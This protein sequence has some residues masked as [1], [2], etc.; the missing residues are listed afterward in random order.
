M[1]RQSA[2]AHLS[3]AERTVQTFVAEICFHRLDVQPAGTPL[4][5]P[6]KRIADL[7]EHRT[8][9]QTDLESM[10][11]SRDIELWVTQSE[12]IKIQEI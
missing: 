6:E 1:A 7:F 5:A 4:I 10:E 11:E 8:R 9:R 3:A 12:I 2:G